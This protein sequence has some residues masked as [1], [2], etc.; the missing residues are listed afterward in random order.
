MPGWNAKHNRHTYITQVYA[1]Y[2]LLHVH[3]YIYLQKAIFGCRSGRGSK[4]IM[5]MIRVQV[6]Q[7]IMQFGCYNEQTKLNHMTSKSGTIIKT[8]CGFPA[9]MNMVAFCLQGSE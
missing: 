6:R 8:K 1:A 3:I 2:I 9:G 7:L 5:S 4:P